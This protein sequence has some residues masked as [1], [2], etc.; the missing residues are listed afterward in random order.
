MV[1]LDIFVHGTGKIITERLARRDTAPDLARGDLKQRRLYIM[2]LRFDPRQFALQLLEVYLFTRTAHHTYP[3]GG[4]DDFFG[5]VPGREVLQGV[6]A[7][8]R[9]DLRLR[10]LLCYQPDRVRGVMGTR[11]VDLHAGDLEGWIVLDGELDHGKPV[12][13][14]GDIQVLFVGWVWS[15]CPEQAGKL[16]LRPCFR[17][18]N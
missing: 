8:D 10:V 3:V 18:Q 1:L 9:H 5:R 16:E 4:I 6:A 17:R 13:E 2:N 15:N 14:G 12:L 11:A 7:D